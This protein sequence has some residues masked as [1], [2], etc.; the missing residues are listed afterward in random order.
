MDN[1]A[2]VDNLDKAI[3]EMNRKKNRREHKVVSQ[4]QGTQNTYQK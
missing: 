4:A 3:L 2:W 1:K